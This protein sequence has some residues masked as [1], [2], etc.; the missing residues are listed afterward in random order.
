M[1]TKSIRDSCQNRMA[2]TAIFGG[3]HVE[4]NPEIVVITASR[5]AIEVSA[6]FSDGNSNF[7]YKHMVTRCECD[8]IEK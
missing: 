7:D 4:W 5:H 1:G 3:E 6:M 8:G 2:S